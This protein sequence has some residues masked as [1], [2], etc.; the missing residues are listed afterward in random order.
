MPMRLRSDRRTGP[1]WPRVVVQPFRNVGGGELGE[2]L[3]IGLTENLIAELSAFDCVEVYA[4]LPGG[5]P[6]AGGS[7]LGFVLGGIVERGLDRVRI[8]AASPTMLPARSPG[9]TGFSVPFRR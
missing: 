1:A 6:L 7:V 3:A 5:S 9:A 8:T 4:D 2:W